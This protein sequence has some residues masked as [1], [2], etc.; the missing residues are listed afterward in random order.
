M[1][2]RYLE[3]YVAVAKKAA[4]VHAKVQRQHLDQHILS[5]SRDPV[6]NLGKGYEKRQ[7]GGGKDIF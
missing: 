1:R 5:R 3:V 2:E 6:D 4:L 7:D